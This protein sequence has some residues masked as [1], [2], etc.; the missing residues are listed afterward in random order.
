MIFNRKNKTAESI[1]HE[2]E[3][4]I[5]KICEYKLKSMPQYIDDCVQDVFLDLV[6]ALKNGAEIKNPRAWL[7]VVANNKIK[8]FYELNSKEK[9]R[10]VSFEE[11]EKKGEM[12][13]GFEESFDID[14][15]SDDEIE[16]M[17]NTVISQLPVDE[18]ELFK[19]Y[20]VDLMKVKEISEE[21]NL[22]ESNVKQRL[23]RMRKNIVYL[24]KKALNQ[25]YEQK[26][27]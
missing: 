20:Y 17:K 25:H 11:A 15:I 19:A 2:N 16:K 14:G 1:R 21:F 13:I 22:T 26:N 3:P 4:Y 23:Y 27:T 8:D 5:R 18:Q 7:T 12:I 9:E 10:F 6:S 24:A